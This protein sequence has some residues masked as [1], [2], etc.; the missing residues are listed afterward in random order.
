MRRR[1]GSANR[2]GA[3]MAWRMPEPVGVRVV[4]ND[5]IETPDGVRLAVSLW[6]PDVAARA[7]VVL[8]SIPYRKRDSTRSYGSW[9][10]RKLAERGVAYARLDC[11]GSG[12]SGGLLLGE[13]LPQEQA[14]N[15]AAIASAGGAALVQRRGR[16]ARGVLG[17]LLHA[18]GRRAGAAGAEGD[19]ADVRL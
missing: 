7:P 4:E 2:V 10:G 5:W 16:H 15:L 13:Y 14:D 12:D 6:L 19:H 17:R 3:L 11:R 8:E 9:W 18:A 1:R